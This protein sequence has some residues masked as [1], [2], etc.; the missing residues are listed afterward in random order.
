MFACLLQRKFDRD[1]KIGVAYAFPLLEFCSLSPLSC[2]QKES[3]GLDFA[4]SA[5]E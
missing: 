1:K 4:H 5:A 2:K 3:V